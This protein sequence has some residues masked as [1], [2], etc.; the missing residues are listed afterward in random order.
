[1]FKKLKTLATS[2]KKDRYVKKEKQEFNPLNKVTATVMGNG[3]NTNYHE[4]FLM[5][6]TKNSSFE[7]KGKTYNIPAEDTGHYSPSFWDFPRK[8]GTF[9]EQHKTTAKFLDWFHFAKN[10]TFEIGYLFLEDNPD[11]YKIEPP[12]YDWALENYQIQHNTTIEGAMKDADKKLKGEEKHTSMLMLVGLIII[13][14]VA[15]IVAIAYFTGNHA[16][17]AQQIQNVT[18]TIPPSN[19]PITG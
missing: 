13:A 16:Q 2:L 12:D 1:L 10:A 4:T 15:V 14:I 8:W 19:L 11:P 3:V 5:D 7:Y 18:A 9:F 6:T 17:A